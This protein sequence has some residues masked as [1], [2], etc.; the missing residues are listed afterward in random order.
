MAAARRHAPSP[1]LF[2]RRG[3][4]PPSICLGATPRERSAGRRSR[5]LRARS[6]LRREERTRRLSALLPLRANGALRGIISRL[7]GA[8]VKP[9]DRRRVRASWDVR[10]ALSQSSRLPA[11]RSLCRPVGSRD[12]PGAWLR[13]T[14]AGTAPDPTF[15]TPHD[16]ALGGSSGGNIVYKGNKSNMRSTKICEAMHYSACRVG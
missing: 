10:F 4:R 13:T 6:S 11:E 9:P 12:L 14:P 5:Q 8:A 3:V 2:G 16:S 7:R 15:M 1:L